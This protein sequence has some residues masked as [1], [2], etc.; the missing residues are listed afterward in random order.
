MALIDT[1]PTHGPVLPSD[2]RGMSN[3]QLPAILLRNFDG[4][5]NLHHLVSYGMEAMHL[6]MLAAGI[7][8]RTVGR[9]RTYAQQVGLFTDRMR[10]SDTGRRPAVTRTWNGRKYWLLP[11]MAP[12]ATPGTSN[13]G[14]GCADDVAEE[15]DGDP[16]PEGMTDNQLLWMRDNAPSFGFALESHSERWHW[17]WTGGDNLPQRALDVLHFCGVPL[18]WEFSEPV[19]VPVTPTPPPDPTPAPQPDPV[20]VPGGSYTVDATRSSV[21]LGS[22]GKMVRRAQFACQLIT[23]SPASVDGNF[24]AVTDEAVK[25][26]QRFFGLLPDGQVGPKT[27]A[28]LEQI[29]ND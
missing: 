26:F 9:Y 3:G 23:G 5:G 24:G 13:H 1:V 19:P 14:W 2:L 4:R 7:Q 29:T 25:N 15:Y 6:A 18:P 21:Q 20:P 27:W 10:P 11:G 12:V 17:C 28:V 22:Q 16:G 8:P